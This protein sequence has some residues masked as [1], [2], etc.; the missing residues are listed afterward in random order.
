[1]TTKSLLKIIALAPCLPAVTAW[2]SS[3][4]TPPTVSPGYDRNEA[5]QDFETTIETAWTAS[6][7]AL[8]AG[9]YVVEPTVARSL[10][11]KADSARV[12]D[13][14]YWLRVEKHTA[15]QVRVRVSV[16]TFETKDHERRSALLLE[17]IEERL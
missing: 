5:Y 4:R 2:P 14:G 10:A 3:L 12:D 13:D 1:M 8:E 15:G 16:G 7:E 9:G 6:I 17:A 11:K